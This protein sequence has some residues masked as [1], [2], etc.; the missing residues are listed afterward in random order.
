FKFESDYGWP[1]D[2]SLG[3][4]RNLSQNT[5]VTLSGAWE[6]PAHIRN[7]ALG[8]RYVPENV[9]YA[10]VESQTADVFA[11]RLQ[12]TGT[13][14]SLRYA[15][16]PDIPKDWNLLPFPINPQYVKQ[17]TLDGK[18]GYDATGG[19]VT[20]VDYPMAATLGEYSYYKPV[21]AY[22]IKAGIDKQ[23]QELLDQY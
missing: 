14:V 3:V 10:L 16:N 18:I 15:P 9:G 2:N 7:P 6:D 23:E 11:L 17:G 19:V 1:S 21:E 22:A 13:L 8:R 5:S 20:D 12:H 4:G